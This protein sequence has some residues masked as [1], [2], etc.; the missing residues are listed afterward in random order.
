MTRKAQKCV[1]KIYAE[2]T[3]KLLDESW[4]VDFSPNET[5][6]PD[7]CVTTGSRTFGLEVRELFPDELAKGSTK[8]ANE[9][10]NLK[11]IQKLANDYYKKNSIPVK[12]DLLGNI[13]Q[14]DQLLS[15][16]T[17]VVSQLSEFQQERLELHTGCVIYVRRLPVQ[18]G[19]YKRWRYVT[20]KVGWVRNIG[21]DLIDRAVEE[22][23]K[24]ISRYVKN[25]DDIRLLLV[26]NRIFNSGKCRL[27]KNIICD[28][29]GFKKIYYLSYPEKVWQLGER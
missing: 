26:S 10:N 1:E 9:Q 3:G 25:M 13:G 8:K 21:K 22:K 12:V 2:E 6:W 20:D 24:N 27:A 19:Q 14:E 7:L 15:A 23:A 29:R 4:K 5:E 11:N 18:L 17:G 16:I 28:T